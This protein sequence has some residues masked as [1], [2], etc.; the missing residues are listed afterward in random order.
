MPKLVPP[1]GSDVVLP[2][3][4]TDANF[5][6]EMARAKSLKRVPVSS[7][8]VSDLF[9]FG[10]GAYTP[11]TGFMNEAEW[12]GV[13]ENMRMPDGL[14]WPIPIT[15][16]TTQKLAS[17]IKLGE[18]VA[19]CDRN[20][21]EILAIMSVCEKYEINN[22]LEIGIDEAGRGPLFGRVYTA[23]V[24]LPKHDNFD[25]KKMR[26]WWLPVSIFS[27]CL[28]QKIRTIAYTI[29]VVYTGF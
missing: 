28:F 3:L 5:A 18:D 17:S 25:F 13:C 15:L 4:T 12:R 14:F 11:L 1:H 21:Q 19:L 10:M 27:V 16:S 29:V 24:I 20:N 22:L 6:E 2:L 23:A 26:T 9:M 7:R 8:E